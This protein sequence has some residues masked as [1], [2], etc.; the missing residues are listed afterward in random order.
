MN[1]YTRYTA[2]A[3]G[4]VQAIGITLGI[5]RAA[6]VSDSVFFILQL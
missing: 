6:L 4:F 2:L 5:V 1:A 3:L